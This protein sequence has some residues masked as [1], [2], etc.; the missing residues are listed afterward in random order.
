MSPVFC[1]SNIDEQPEALVSLLGEVYDDMP[2]PE[3]LDAEVKSIGMVTQMCLVRDDIEDLVWRG[4]EITGF[5]ATEAEIVRF[6]LQNDPDV[7]GFIEFCMG[8]ADE[9]AVEEAVSDM[10]HADSTKEL[11]DISLESLYEYAFERHCEGD[12]LGKMAHF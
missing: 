9:I 1:T 10:L 8:L 3:E 11:A 5:M 7:G 4:C 6:C 2:E 12:V